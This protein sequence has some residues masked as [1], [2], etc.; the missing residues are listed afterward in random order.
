M[1]LWGLMNGT[2]TSILKIRGIH[3]LYYHVQFNNQ[4]RINICFII[5]ACFCLL[6][7]LANPAVFDLLEK[8]HIQVVFYGKVNGGGAGMLTFILLFI[9]MFMNMCITVFTKKLWIRLIP[10]WLLLALLIPYCWVEPYLMSVYMAVS[11]C[12]FMLYSIITKLLL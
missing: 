8:L 6:Y 3:L 1:I 10:L 11:A 5:N 4:M 12:I 9:S 2:K 7:C